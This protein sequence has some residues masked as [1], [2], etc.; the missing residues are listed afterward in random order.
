MKW[1]EFSNDCGDGTSRQLRFKTREEAQ[2]ARDFMETTDNFL[3]DGD[4]SPVVEVNTDSKYFFDSL[5][6]LKGCH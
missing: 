5:E 6:E 3:C 4:G 2:A 1:Y